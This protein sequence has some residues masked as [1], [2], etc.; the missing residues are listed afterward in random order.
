MEDS[1]IV[2]GF[3]K[4][5][6]M[7]GLRYHKL[8][9]DSDSS[10]YHKIL[11]SRPYKNITVEKVEC[12]NHLLRNLCNKLKDISTKK[13]AG[14]L[15]HRKLL[16]NNIVRIRKGIVCAIS[17]RKSNGHSVSDLRSDIMNTNHHVCRNKMS[18]F[19]S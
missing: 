12:R 9:A 1:I 11:E 10:V 8:I 2:E 5:E 6:E 15:V 19:C 4:S 17:Y 13:S 3:N 14:K 7:Y 18:V 16:S